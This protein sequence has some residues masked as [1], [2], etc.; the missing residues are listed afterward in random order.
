MSTLVA[1]PC[2]IPYVPSRLRRPS[3]LSTRCAGRRVGSCGMASEEGRLHNRRGRGRL[4]AAGAGPNHQ[5][6]FTDRVTVTLVVLRLQLPHTALAVLYGVD[7]STITRAVHEIRS[8]L[9]ACGLA[10]PGRLDLRLRTVEDVFAYA[11]AEGVELRLD[12]T[13]V[14]V[15]RPG[16]NRPGRRAFVSG[17]MQQNT[18]KAT[19]VTDEQ[20]RTLWA[21]AFRPGRVHDQTAVKTAGICDLF[22]RYPAVRAKVDAG[23]QGL[24]KQF[25][26]RSR[27]RPPLKPKKHAPPGALTARDAGPAASS[28][29]NE[30]A[31]STPMPSTRSGDTPAVTQTPRVPRR[32]LLGGGR[33]CLRSHHQEVST[34]PT[35]C[36]ANT[37]RPQ[38]R[39]SP[40]P[41]NLCGQSIT[42]ARAP[43]PPTYHG[44]IGARLLAAYHAVIGQR[45]LRR[46]PGTALLL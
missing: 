2:P 43:E 32:K 38:S 44:V 10:V 40:D 35:T 42:R 30:S 3:A 24:A 16:A 15:R 33:P 1:R 46:S 20:G 45:R 21:G 5:L 25:P 29:Q 12:G 18:K 22:E 41:A 34:H 11:A 36:Q 8:L 6:V 23:Y 26:T 39:E 13:E 19:V 17:K 27:P 4:R 9:A 28:H 7:R 31:S 37:P 14:R